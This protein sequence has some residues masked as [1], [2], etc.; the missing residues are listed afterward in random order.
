MTE[1]PNLLFLQLNELNFPF[2]MDY[3]QRGMLPNFLRFF[4]RHGFVETVSESEHRLANPWIQWP[5]VHT[6]LDYH[7]HGVFRLGDIVKTDHPSI[8]DVLEEHGVRV[9]ALGAFN[10]RNSTPN[11]VFFVADPWTNT[12][13][14]APPSVRRIDKAVRQVTDDYAKNRIAMTSIVDLGL[15]GMANMHWGN[16]PSYLGETARFIRGQKWMRAVVGDRLLGDTFLTQCAKLKPQF[17]TLFLNGGAHLQHH[18]MFSSSA[19]KGKNRNPAWVAPANKDPLLDILK[20]YDD[21]LGRAVQFA[22]GLPGGRILIATA[23]HQEP[24]ERETY[25]Y[26]L[27]DQVE[28]LEMMGIDYESTYRLM[29]EDFVVAFESEETAAAAEKMLLDIRT[30]G[31]DPIFYVETGDSEIRTSETDSQIFHV[32]NRGKDLYLQLRPMSRQAPAGAKVGRGNITVPNFDKL[33]SFAQYKNTHHHGIGYYSDSA[34]AP[35]DLPAQFPLRDIYPLIL[36]AFEISHAKVTNMMP[37]LTHATM[38]H[39]G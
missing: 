9:A 12:P 7:D 22:E 38:Q 20:S 4:D 6:G 35:G 30:S 18:Y 21:F 13:V 26:R 3:A 8:Y 23:L 14:T 5:T 19:Y 25:Y 16:L 36:S 37:A 28:F 31:I 32:E 34:F 29:T 39:T 24:H 15:G 27:D 10:A 33:I 1:S 11:P 17:A 2:I